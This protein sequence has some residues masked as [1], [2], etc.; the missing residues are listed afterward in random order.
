MLREESKV[1]LS[2]VYLI[3]NLQQNF[4]RVSFLSTLS[5][6]LNPDLN[7]FQ[8]FHKKSKMIF[9]E[10]R[11]PYVQKKKCFFREA[12][13]FRSLE[14]PYIHKGSFLRPSCRKPQIDQSTLFVS[15]VFLN[16]WHKAS[17]EMH[18]GSKTAEV[19]Q[20][21]MNIQPSS[22]SSKPNRRS[23]LVCF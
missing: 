22:H 12:F 4:G 14:L 11:V 17:I 16:E 10:G 1:N 2:S 23:T 19:S 20:H 3:T 7:L 21:E 8:L 15:C 5:L 13:T 18:E 9:V 6:R